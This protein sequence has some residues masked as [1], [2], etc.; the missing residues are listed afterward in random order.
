MK[1]EETEHQLRAYLDG[2]VEA[3]LRRVLKVHLSGCPTCARKLALLGKAA[4]LFRGL[5][6][7]AAPAGFDAELEV[8]L[9]GLGTRRSVWPDLFDFFGARR[10]ALAAVAAIVLLLFGISSLVFRKHEAP[11]R[12]AEAFFAGRRPYYAVT[13]DLSVQ[14]TVPLGPGRCLWRLGRKS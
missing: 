4:A 6:L 3:D 8:K 1:C 13:A 11:D 7:S 10:W 12:Y 14:D 9:R 2:E 5:P